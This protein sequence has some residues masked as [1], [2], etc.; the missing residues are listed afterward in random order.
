MTHIDCFIF[1]LIKNKMTTVYIVFNR[2]HKSCNCEVFGVYRT[3]EEAIKYLLGFIIDG[4]NP[5]K[6]DTGEF[7]DQCE[8]YKMARDDL[9]NT[10]TT[11]EEYEIIEVEVGKKWY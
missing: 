2:T 8:Y 6:C 5:E 11:E 4:H 1:S 9:I 3:K 10:G 7:C